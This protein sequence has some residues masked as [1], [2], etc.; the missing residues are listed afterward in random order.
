[1][2]LVLGLPR[3][4]L[5]QMLAALKNQL[6]VQFVLGGLA[7]DSDEPMAPE[8]QQSIQAHWRRIADELGTEFN[9][10]FWRENQPRRAT[11]PAC[12]AVIAAR[13]QDAEQAMIHA[14]QQAYYLRAMNPSD[15]DTLLQLA[16]EM[17]LDF[18]SFMQ[19]LESAATEQQL[20]QEVALARELFAKSGARGFP[21]W[22]LIH[23]GKALAVPLDYH[24]AQTSLAAISDILRSG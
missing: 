23:D 24:S 7:P 21:S 13:A 20:Q 5:Q 11:Y 4:V 2:Q 19:D 10:A 14:I 12:R 3:P 17:G 22:V 9:F 1:M 6:P 18:D 8:M 15:E 16:D